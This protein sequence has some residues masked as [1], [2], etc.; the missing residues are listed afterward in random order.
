MIGLRPNLL[1]TSNNKS[2]SRITLS[3]LRNSMATQSER[4]EKIE[5]S[6]RFLVELETL[7]AQ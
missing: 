3:T 5:L 4:N 1:L 6:R 7:L 2:D